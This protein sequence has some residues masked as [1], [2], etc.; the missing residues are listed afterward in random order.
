MYP[1]PLYDFYCLPRIII[2][3]PSR[4]HLGHFTFTPAHRKSAEF[5]FSLYFCLIFIGRIE[6]DV[7]H[8]VYVEHP[9]YI[10]GVCCFVT[11][12]HSLLF[13]FYYRNDTKS[14]N[15]LAHGGNWLASQ[16][17]TILVCLHIFHECDNKTTRFTTL[18]MLIFLRR[19]RC[20]TVQNETYFE[21][22][23]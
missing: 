13:Q 4:F 15:V 14:N 23:W 1:V 18:I 6:N 2:E 10:L 7:S 16:D 20:F 11:Q 12:R 22:V 5:T 19:S 9:F 17:I 3:T 21:V 8:N